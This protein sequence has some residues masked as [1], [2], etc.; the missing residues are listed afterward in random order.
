MAPIAGYPLVVKLLTK[1]ANN[2][3]VMLLGETGSGKSTLLNMFVNFFRGP[4]QARSALPEAKDLRAAVPT[5]HIAVTEPEGAAHSE[6]NV[7]DR[8]LLAT[9]SMFTDDT[10]TR[11][12]SCACHGSQSRRITLLVQL[13]F[14]AVLVLCTN[15]KRV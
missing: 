2:Y 4:A 12:E 1:L 5:A 14:E 7:T 10:R 15:T 9:W 11:F 13:H 8:T 3:Y 6:R